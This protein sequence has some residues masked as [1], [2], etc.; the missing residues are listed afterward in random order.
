MSAVS[1]ESRP[2]KAVVRKI[3]FEA[4]R[5]LK[6]IAAFS[7]YQY[8]GFGALEFMDF[9]LAHRSLGIERMISIERNITDISR[10]EWNRPFNGIKVLPG[11]A[12]NVLPTLDW[13][14]LSV[15]W[16]DYT[17]TLTTE[18]IQDV[19]SMARVLIPGSVLAVTVNAHP[20]RFNERVQALQ[21][22]VGPARVPLGVAESKLTGWGLGDV[23]WEILNASILAT[24]SDRLDGGRW[25]Q[26]LNIHYQ[27]SARM[28]MVVGI[29]S[30]VSFDRT[31]EMCRFDDLSELRTASE[32]LVVH[33]PL[34]TR[35]EKDWINQ[36]IPIEADGT[37]PSL[38]GIKSEDVEEYCRIYRWLESNAL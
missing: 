29:V 37:S 1:Y 12:G 27:D 36:R 9:D 20:G 5:H 13:Q 19:E 7:D 32:A 24:I 30:S 33:V 14:Q 17:S 26:L 28:Q 34:L 10:Y 6:P 18:V 15:V 4:L 21:E 3:F 8:V 25:K 11:R 38:P 31:V 16:L 22:A 2:S 35:R 23:Q